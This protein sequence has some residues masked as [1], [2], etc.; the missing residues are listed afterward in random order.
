MQGEDQPQLV[1]I[2]VRGTDRVVSCGAAEKVL[3][4]IERAFHRSGPLPVRVGCRQ[5]GC[6]AC[7]VRVLSGRYTTGKMSREHVTEEEERQGYALA[8]RIHPLGDLE[9]EP[10]F[11]GPRGRRERQDPLEA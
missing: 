8:C 7:R 1:E 11:R 10:A 2:R 5:G 4:A 6:G 9:I 3:V